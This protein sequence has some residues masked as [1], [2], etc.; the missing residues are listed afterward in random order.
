M[1]YKG[2][3]DAWDG[4]GGAFLYTRSSSFDKALIPRLDAA[5]ERTQGPYKW[6]D[7]TIT[8]NSCKLQTKDPITLREQYASKVLIT[9]EE[10]L[11]NQL[12]T[13]RNTAASNI[14]KSEKGAEKSLVKLEKEAEKFVAEIE[15]E[16]EK[17]VVA[18]E[19]EVEKD[20]VA[21]EKEVE[22]DV[23]AVEKEVER[24]IS[25]L[26]GFNKKK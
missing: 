1:Y 25:S 22:K 7:F 9:T 14:D 12:T 20:V 23:V 11:Q 13:L 24:D 17:D 16:V 26:F 10:Q 5:M 4:Y 6:S 8:D 21:V 18:V 15:K 3:N 2:S 19:K